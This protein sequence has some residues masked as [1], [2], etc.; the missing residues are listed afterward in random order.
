MK[1][2]ENQIY[3]GMI[4]EISH[5]R[6]IDGSEGND[7]LSGDFILNYSIEA[8]PYMARAVTIF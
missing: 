8:R 1:K 7:N 6:Q 3:R 5:Q 2:G 4:N